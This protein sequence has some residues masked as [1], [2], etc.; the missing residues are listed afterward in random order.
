MADEID[1]AAEIEQFN[2]EMA[3]KNRKRPEFNFT[4]ECAWCGEKIKAGEYC[5]ADCRDDHQG[6][7]RAQQQRRIG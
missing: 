5:N 1:A 7:I 4:G 6:Y 3:I 2:T